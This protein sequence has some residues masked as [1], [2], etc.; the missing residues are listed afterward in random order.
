MPL[1]EW[2]AVYL[3]Y[4]ISSSVLFLIFRLFAVDSCFIKKEVFQSMNHFLKWLD[5]GLHYK[6]SRF[7]LKQKKKIVK[8]KRYFRLIVENVQVLFLELLL[9]QELVWRIFFKIVFIY[10]DVAH[11]RYN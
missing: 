8:R 2:K 10:D 9:V 1:D 7:P 4:F 5:K 3:V 6:G 11:H